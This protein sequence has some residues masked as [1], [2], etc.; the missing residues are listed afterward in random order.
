MD[1]VTPYL[2]AAF[3]YIILTFPIATWL[4]TW[5]SRKKKKLG[6]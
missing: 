2:A 1:P 4:D 5:G 6:L 3:L